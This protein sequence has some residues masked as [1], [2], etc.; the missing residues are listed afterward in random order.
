MWCIRCARIHPATSL[1]LH[2]L[3][4]DYIMSL[5]SFPH[6][7][8]PN[9]AATWHRR[10]AAHNGRGTGTGTGP[11]TSRFS[12][13]RR[14]SEDGSGVFT[15]NGN[16]CECRPTEVV[17]N[18]YNCLFN[19]PAEFG[20]TQYDF[21]ILR[22]EGMFCGATTREKFNRGYYIRGMMYGGNVSDGSGLLISN[23][24]PVPKAGD[25]VGVIVD[26]QPSTLIV[27]FSHNGTQLGEAFRVPAPYP[28]PLFPVVGF[29]TGGGAVRVEKKGGGQGEVSISQPIYLPGGGSGG[30]NGGEQFPAG[31][32]KL[33]AVNRTNV[34]HPVTLQINVNGPDNFRISGQAINSFSTNV[35]RQGASWQSTP[36]PSTMMAGPEDF[37]NLE[38]QVT[39]TL[40][41]IRD[42]R[43]EGSYLVI[44]GQFD[45]LQFAPIVG[46]ATKPAVMHNVL[47]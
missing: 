32:W 36:M 26:F 22:G 37:M 33:L 21:T 39:G 17:D 8:E 29:S 38:G 27:S 3:I 18:K 14:W 11:A 4:S 5:H 12:H 40:S 24:G 31:R 35:T 6:H 44:Q 15:L 41:S 1:V 25:V 2:I 34:G 23:F 45:S 7:K 47:A 43:Q 30:G 13:K 28:K 20:K 46:Q 42:F 9:K 10:A 19:D 16:T